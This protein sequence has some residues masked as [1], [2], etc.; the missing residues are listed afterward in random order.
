M[1]KIIKT[2]EYDDSWASLSKGVQE[3]VD[4]VMN[5]LIQEK[6]V[7]TK[8]VKK[9]KNTKYYEMRISLD[10]EYRFI[11]YPIDNKIIVEA[12]QV[13]ALNGFLKKSTKDYKRQLIIADK[14]L[15][16]LSDEE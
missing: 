2:K 15:K 6:V 4:Y 5:I 10:N 16:T 1:R 8:F 9:L 3:K 11:L 12:N 7:S 13:I 14:I